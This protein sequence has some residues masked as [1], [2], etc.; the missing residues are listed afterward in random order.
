MSNKKFIAEKLGLIRKDNQSVFASIVDPL[1][2]TMEDSP[3]KLSFKVPVDGNWFK[4]SF[5]AL[6]LKKDRLVINAERIRNGF[7]GAQYIVEFK[8]TRAAYLRG[9]YERFHQGG[10]W[11]YIHW[12]IRSYANHPIDKNKRIYVSGFH[13][14]DELQKMIQRMEQRFGTKNIINTYI[15]DNLLR[16]QIGVRVGKTP[17]EIEK[18]WSKG[19]MEQLGYKYVEALDTGPKKGAWHS[20][21]V[22]WH[23]LKLD[24]LL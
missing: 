18:K 16:L 12:D 3:E 19:M 24:A 5:T 13:A 4:L 23:K 11:P 1:S 7:L 14:H 20:A 22:H 9:Y 10:K 2:K 6:E 17:A 21:K 8:G 15:N